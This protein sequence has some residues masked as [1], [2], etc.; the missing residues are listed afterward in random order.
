ML[1]RTTLSLLIF[2]ALASSGH[3]AFL[4]NFATSATFSP[5]DSEATVQSSGAANITSGN[6][7]IYI[8]YQQVSGIDQNPIIASFTNGIQDWAITDYDTSAV[9]ARGLGL[10]WNTSDNRLYAAFS[11]DGGANAGAYTRFNDSG[12]MDSAWQ[13]SYG[14][15][16]GSKVSVIYELNPANGG[17]LGGTYLIAKLSNGNT[18]TIQISDFGWSDDQLVVYAS[19]FFSP[20]NP[21][22]S[23]MTHDGGSSPFDYRGLF[24]AD[25]STLNSA[26]AIGFNGV[27]E[28]SPIPEPS[29]LSLAL[30]LS[31][32][33][34][35]AGCRRPSGK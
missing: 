7:T 34:G 5:S 30:G 3:A 25:L 9:D 4:S 21:D 18:N 14:S 33:L 10:G 11:T 27:T 24:S 28:F 2:F 23:R 12:R 15:G 31:A 6:T 13:G 8:G 32:L 16:G 17:V 1:R 22:K 35:I 29:Q 26:E 19:S 20:L